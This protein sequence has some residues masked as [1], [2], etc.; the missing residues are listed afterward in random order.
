MFPY[1]GKASRLALATAF[2]A[3][4]AV[5]IAHEAQTNRRGLVIRGIIRLAPDGANIFYWAVTALSVLF[6]TIGLL[7][8]ASRLFG[9]ARH[10]TLTTTH[11]VV[12]QGLLSRTDVAVPYAAIRDM[13]LLA[14]H[15]Q[16]FLEIRH[17]GGRV[18]IVQAAMPSGEA[19]DELRRL[20]AVRV[21]S[22]GA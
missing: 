18:S 7:G 2:F 19:F 1:R 14:V 4:C 5:A 16:T 6:A 13:R 20:L 8:L 22:A 11:I 10:L 15:K 9:G 12:P 17:A 3:A 21:R